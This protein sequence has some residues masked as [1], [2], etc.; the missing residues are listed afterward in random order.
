MGRRGKRKGNLFSPLPESL[1]VFFS[2][3]Q[4]RRAVR[5]WL[6]RDYLERVER[7]TTDGLDH[8]ATQNLCSKKIGWQRGVAKSRNRYCKNFTLLGRQG[9]MIWCYL[10]ALRLRNE[11]AKANHTRAHCLQWLFFPGKHLQALKLYLRR[12][13]CINVYAKENSVLLTIARDEL[14][15]SGSPARRFSAFSV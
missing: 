1:L 3:P 10:N 11:R 15:G 6:A 9:K 2:L 8:V 5:S 12:K 14:K 4:S 13:Y 7:E